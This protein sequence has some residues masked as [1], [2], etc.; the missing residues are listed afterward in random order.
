LKSKDNQE[1]ERYV[2]RMFSGIAHRYDLMNRMMT[3]GRDE[4]WRKEVIR[5]A[6]IPTGGLLLDLGSGTGDLAFEALR[7]YPSCRVIP[8]DFTIDMM[9]IGRA[10]PENQDKS[11]DMLDW[12]AVDANFIPFHDEVFDAVVSG[13]LLRNVRDVDRCLAEQYRVTAPGGHIAALDTT[14]PPQ[15]I[16]SPFIKLHLRYLIPTLGTIIAGQP[17]AYRYLPNTT[18]SFLHPQQ[19]S[20]RLQKA[21]FEKVGYQ[22]LMFGTVA[23]YWGTKPESTTNSLESQEGE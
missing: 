18:E 14:P 12:S 13:F 8:A 7:Q 20:A 21:G 19:L 2:Q 9:R 1:H 4:T 17:D 3:A 23:I 22:H 5:R 10:R 6:S 15:S 11:A 16:F